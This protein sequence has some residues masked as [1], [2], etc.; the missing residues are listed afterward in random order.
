M[1]ADGDAALILAARRGDRAA[2]GRLVAAHQQA[3]RGF[4]RRAGGDA[5]E[6]DDLAQET[7]IA[8][9]TRLDQFRG[10]ASFRSWLCGIGW[11]KLQGARRTLQ[12]GRARDGAYLRDVAPMND[13]GLDPATRLTLTRAMESLPLDQRACVA[14][15]LAAGMSHGEAAAALE[16]PLG[17]VKSHVMRGRARLHAALG[18]NEGGGDV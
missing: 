7:F 15:C 12:R 18:G 10:Q 1:S 3:V 4:L 13:D 9:W 14:L 2:F 8:A 16:L 17:T 5:S 6:A 11:R